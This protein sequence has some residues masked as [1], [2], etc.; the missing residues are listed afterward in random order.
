MCVFIH[1]WFAD[2]DANLLA[3]GATVLVAFLLWEFVRERRRRRKRNSERTARERSRK[4]HW[5]YV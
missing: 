1:P 5:G 2:A 4:D 3:L